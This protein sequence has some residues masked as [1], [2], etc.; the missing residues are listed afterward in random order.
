MPEKCSG[1]LP[2]A[3]DNTGSETGVFPGFVVMVFF[4]LNDMLCLL[5]KTSYPPW[6]FLVSECFSCTVYPAIITLFYS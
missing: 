4:I 6:V 2:D 3:G 1:Q 5:W